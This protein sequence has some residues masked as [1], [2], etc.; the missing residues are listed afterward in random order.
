MKR[1]A[2]KEHSVEVRRGEMQ[3]KCNAARGRGIPENVV[4][5]MAA[6]WECQALCVV[7]GIMC[8]G[9]VD[10]DDKTKPPQGPQ[11]QEG[12]GSEWGHMCFPTTIIPG[13]RILLQ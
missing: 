8:G 13:G 4:Q 9:S 11:T 2:A 10:T 6:Q 1:V 5:I 7:E 12:I 3:E